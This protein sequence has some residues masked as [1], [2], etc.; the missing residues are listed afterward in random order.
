MLLDKVDSLPIKNW[1]INRADA[2]LRLEALPEVVR[3]GL[4]DTV[5]VS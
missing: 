2:P 3:M 1:Q 5:M 4:F